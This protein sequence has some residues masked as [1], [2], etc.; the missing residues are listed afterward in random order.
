M[1]KFT[2][3][4]ENKQFLG[5][6]KEMIFNEFKSHLNPTLLDITLLY[7]SL[8]KDGSE[9]FN[10]EGSESDR[11][12]P[13]LE[14]KLFYPMFLIDMNLGRLPNSENF[15]EIDNK[16]VDNWVDETI[17][18]D[19]IRDEFNK[20]SNFLDGYKEYFNISLEMSGGKMKEQSNSL[21]SYN[22]DS[23]KYN[24]LS[25]TISLIMKDC[26]EYEQIR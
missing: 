19:L 4:T 26:F 22:R 12:S 25:I 21:V 1:K 13:G 2:K 6:S 5:Y 10:F 20:L 7:I 9:V 17:K 14:D 8:D 23:K 15:H 24:I 16:Q 18:F 3:I 11:N